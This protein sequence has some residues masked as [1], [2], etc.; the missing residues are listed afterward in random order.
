[1]IKSTEATTAE[2]KE[3]AAPAKK[4]EAKPVKV[5]KDAPVAGKKVVAPAV[6]ADEGEGEDLIGEI[7]DAIQKEAKKE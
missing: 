5:V 4:P 1:M 6:E 7:K 2:K 3:P